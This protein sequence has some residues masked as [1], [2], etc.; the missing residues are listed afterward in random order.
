MSPRDMD[1]Q[2][3][4]SGVFADVQFMRKYFPGREYFIC[5]Q[6]NDLIETLFNIVRTARG[7]GGVLAPPFG[8]CC[9]T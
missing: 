6:G 4:L 2:C 7:M 8:R 1:M 5:L 3:E 9:P